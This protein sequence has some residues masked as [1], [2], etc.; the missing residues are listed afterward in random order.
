MTSAGSECRGSHEVITRCRK[1]VQTFHPE[2][3]AVR[4]HAAYKGF[5]AFLRA[6]ECFVLQRRDTTGFVT[7]RRVFSHRLTVRQEIVLEVVNEGNGLVE[8]AFVRTA[9]HEDGLSAEHLRYFGQYG[10]T[11]LCYK[12]V[13]K[14]TQERVRS[15]T[16]ESVRAAAFE[17]DAQFAQRDRLA[18]VVLGL[19]I[20]LAQDRHAVLHFVT[21][22]LL[23]C[24]EF[25]A[26]FVDLSAELLEDI[27]LIVLATER[28]DKDCSC[29]RVMD[30]VAEDFLGVLVVIA[31]LRAPVVMGEGEDVVRACLLTET[32]GTFLDDAIHATHGR[33][34]PH[35]VADTHL[36]VFAS[37]AHERASLVGDVEDDLFGVVLIGEQPREVRF[38][39]V[40]VHPRAGFL[41]LFRMTNRET[42]L[43]DVLALSEIG[44]GYFVSGRH[45]LQNGDLLTVHFNNR[46]G[47]L[48]L[49]CYHHII[50]R[51]DFKNIGHIR[52]NF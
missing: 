13:A 18:F 49:Y 9:I 21:L 38:D 14:H 8:E 46:T 35:F 17:T 41:R 16:A 25:N 2:A 33:D 1:E 24:N 37:V 51:I 44:D 43:D 40:L 48:R 52:T 31:E 30:H 20:E 26:L 5:A 11:T 27:R 34:D 32:L 42:V 47:G 23:G 29:V 28:N 22:N 4:H 12:P 45:V 7:R 19:G 50:R 39:V 6:T 36:S 10:C 15:D 3:F